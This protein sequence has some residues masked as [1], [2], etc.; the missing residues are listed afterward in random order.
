MRDHE[1]LQLGVCLL[2]PLGLLAA[3]MWNIGA[4]HGWS[5][6]KIAAHVLVVVVSVASVVA[7]GWWLSV[8]REAP[9]LSYEAGNLGC[10]AIRPLDIVGLVVCVGL[11][12]VVLWTLRRF[13]KPAE[14]GTEPDG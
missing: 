9:L 3:L 12:G 10:G 13:S 4:H 1:L 7:I 11:L 6:R 5:G 2:F 8:S 14:S